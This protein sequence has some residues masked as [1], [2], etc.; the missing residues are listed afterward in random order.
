M[1]R[2]EEHRVA[3]ITYPALHRP[4]GLPLVTNGPDN[5]NLNAKDDPVR[6]RCE[7]HRPV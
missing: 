7:G 4:V 5:A 2:Q 3:S 6:G 1:P